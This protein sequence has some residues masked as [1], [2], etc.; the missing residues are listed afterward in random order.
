MLREVICGVFCLS[1]ITCE[2]EIF[3]VFNELLNM[4]AFGKFLNQSFINDTLN[5]Q[6]IQSIFG[7]VDLKKHNSFPTFSTECTAVILNLV[8]PFIGQ[9]KSEVIKRLFIYP[10][11]KCKCIYD[12]YAE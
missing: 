5:F 3:P 4:A 11:G 2:N 1:M 6:N 9:N 10:L 8:S 7:N 12:N